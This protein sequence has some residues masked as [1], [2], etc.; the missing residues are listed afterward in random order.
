MNATQF[1]DRAQVYQACEVAFEMI[2]ELN[3][4]AAGP[5]YRRGEIVA[6]KCWASANRS[7][8]Q[9]VQLTFTMFLAIP[10]QAWEQAG[11]FK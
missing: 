3:K 5:V 7:L 11:V 1:F 4:Q 9:R 6:I 8:E 2:D 10:Q